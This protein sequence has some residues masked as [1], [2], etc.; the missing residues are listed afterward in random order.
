[1]NKIQATPIESICIYVVKTKTYLVEMIQQSLFRSLRK[2]QKK[3][4]QQLILG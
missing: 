3:K 2:R 4:Q 1:M